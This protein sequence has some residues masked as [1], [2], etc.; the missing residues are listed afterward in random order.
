MEGALDLL[1][2]LTL[3]EHGGRWGE[4]DGEGGSQGEGG[5]Q[6]HEGDG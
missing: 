1:D 3:L 4:E 5:H 6:E 2:Q